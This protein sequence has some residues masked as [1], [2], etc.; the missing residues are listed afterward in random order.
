MTHLQQQDL[1]PAHARVSRR[2]VAKGVAWTVPAIALA[3]PAPAMAV[4]GPKPTLVPKAAAKAPGNSCKPIV[5]GYV[6]PLDVTNHDPSK[7]IYIYRVEILSITISDPVFTVNN[8]IYP[9]EVPVGSTVEV[10]FNA[11]GDN[12]ANLTFSADIAVYWGHT[13]DPANDADHDHDPM[14]TTVSVSGTPPDYC[15]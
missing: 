5:K 3:A 4:S 15:K 1:H 13:P 9:I 11:G 14:L 7:S 6:F 10:P 2:T 12:S 8:A